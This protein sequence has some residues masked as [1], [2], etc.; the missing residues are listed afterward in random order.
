M[1]ENNKK[2][3][4]EL[5]MHRMFLAIISNI[6][7]QF[8]LVSSLIFITNISIN[9][10]SW[11]QNTWEAITSLRMWLYFLVFAFITF[12]QGIIYSKSYLHHP[13]YLKNR[14][15][16]IQKVFTAQNLLRGMLCIL[17]GSSLAWL[18]LSLRKSNRNLLIGNCSTMYGSCLIE[19]H[20]FLLLGGLWTGL[21]FFI[22]TSSYSLRYFHFTII[23]QTKFSQFRK[24]ISSMLP[25]VASISLWPAIYFV[26]GYYFLGYHM[27]NFILCIASVQI[28]TKPLDSFPTLLNASLI[29]YLWLYQ[30][31]FI[32]MNKT[33]ALLFEIFLTEWIPFEIQQNNVFDNN[34]PSMTLA[35]ILSIENIPIM[36]HLGYLDLITLAQKQKERRSILFTLSQPGGHPYN[37]NC[38]IGK[39]LEIIQK[40]SDELIAVT[41]KSKEQQQLPSNSVITN[42]TMSNMPMF[43][44][45]HTYHMRSLVTE[46]VPSVNESCKPAENEFFIYKYIKTKKE[47]LVTYFLS[48]PLIYYVFGEQEDTKLQYALFKAQ[49]VIW[50]AEAIS[51]LSV[52]SIKE[53]SYG[54]VQK[55]LP[56]IINA[57][58]ALKQ[59]LDKLQKSNILTKKPQNSDRSVKQIF[60]SLRS[61]SKRSLYRI[62]VG[63]ED[64]IYDLAL[65]ITVMEQL[66]PFLNYKE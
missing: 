25:T 40:F 6:V 46:M 37:W 15:L 65:D 48:K 32:L 61:A 7:L 3:Y 1:I 5:L 43:Q 59:S 53:D 54:I 49:A 27:R 10:V 62:T 42:S 38:I 41:V 13:P 55:D 2:G 63:F 64:Y 12:L 23:P 50:A 29:F 33:M 16:K 57:L 52:V 28:E 56:I 58:L 11:L 24:G 31:I 47:M 22:T 36:Q 66:Q 51:S 9:I 44:S 21:Y 20:Y 60:S 26:I 8:F 14:F 19:E 30:S 34:N 18:H 4:R 35:D 17:I 45:E 39:C